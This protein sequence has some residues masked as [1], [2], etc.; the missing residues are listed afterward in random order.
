[1]KNLK[2]DNKAEYKLKVG[3]LEVLGDISGNGIQKIT[4]KINAVEQSVSTVI[5]KTNNYWKAIA[6]DNIITPD[7]KKNLKRDWNQ[8][9]Q[10]YAAL[11]EIAEEKAQVE[12]VPVQEL[13]AAYQDLYNY[14]F[15]TIKLFD[16]M[17]S[18]TEVPS[19]IEFNQK[20][21]TFY[22]KQYKAQSFLTEGTMGYQDFQFAEGT[23]DTYPED[24]EDW[25][26]APPEIAYNKYLWFRTRWTNE[27]GAGTWTYSRLK[28]DS[29]P[30]V[31]ALYSRDGKTNWHEVFSGLQ[32]RFMKLSYDQGETWTEAMKIVGEDGAYTYCGIVSDPIA[33]PDSKEGNYFLAGEDFQVNSILVVNGK[34]LLVNG[35]YMTV[36][37]NIYKGYIYVLEAGS[38][39]QI[40]DRNDYRY[41]ISINDLI[42]IG[43]EVS[44]GIQATVRNNQPMYLGMYNRDP[45]GLPGDWYTY[46]G[47]DIITEDPIYTRRTSYIY[48]YTQNEDG[49]YSWT[50]LP[51][52]DTRN[53][54]KYMQ[55]LPD[56]LTAK[57]ADLDEGYFATVF[58]N[59]LIANT[60]FIKKLAT[61]MIE[62][63][64]GGVIKSN[65]YNGRINEKGE[66]TDYGDEGWAIGY[67]GKADIVNL[68]VTGGIFNDVN[69]EGTVKAARGL[70]VA[71]NISI[72]NASII[73]I[74]NRIYETTGFTEDF[75]L[76]NGCAFIKWGY[77]GT[78]GSLGAPIP[79]TDDS[80]FFVAAIK[81]QNV[82]AS[83]T[84]VI[85]LRLKTYCLDT[86]VSPAEFIPMDFIIP[87]D[88]D[89]AI[90]ATNNKTNVSREITINKMEIEIIY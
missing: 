55:A 14:L 64:E 75:I 19:S 11:M 71:N 78:S 81:I 18:N 77:V 2:E 68:N 85:L 83:G 49:S 21:S 76:V 61:Q 35:S 69:V 39:Q 65:N 50:E 7:E 41:V 79:I 67:D 6:T 17:T 43:A 15:R 23:I 22:D 84:D 52:T 31:Q 54:S 90:M 25:Y 5:E 34:A 33:L 38:W 20:F 51:T 53:Y 1:M 82:P 10:T 28:G 36:P 63:Q 13:Q 73:D 45:E 57:M 42:D 37:R 16:D 58:A 86:G 72:H 74:V 40:E 26:D 44:P 9:D 80:A 27:E 3:S 48:K 30:K 59:S 60:A 8:I 29:G 66:I 47:P 46:N 56:V 4:R 62:L 87:N 70:R 89:W 32:D 12:S 88:N 24:E